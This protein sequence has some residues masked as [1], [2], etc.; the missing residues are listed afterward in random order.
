VYPVVRTLWD[1]LDVN[2][3]SIIKYRLH[4]CPDASNDCGGQNAS[5]CRYIADA[6]PSAIGKPNSTLNIT[7]DLTT[8]DVTLTLEGSACTEGGDGRNHH[9]FIRFQC[10]KTL[11]IKLISWSRLITFFEFNGKWIWQFYWP[12]MGN[13]IDIVGQ[14]RSMVCLSHWPGMSMAE[15][16]IDCMVCKKWRTIIP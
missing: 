8:R 13:K 5:V 11:V 12:C 10:G 9:T 3:S 15:H 4:P 1:V 2:G 6:A 16:I 14:I 7:E